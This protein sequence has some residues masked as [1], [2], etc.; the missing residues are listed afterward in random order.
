VVIAEVIKNVL[1]K[2]TLCLGRHQAA[3]YILLAPTNLHLTRIIINWL[4]MNIMICLSSLS[5]YNPFISKH[6][7]KTSGPKA[8]Q[9]A[10]L[11]T[12]PKKNFV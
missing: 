8:P 11:Q 6:G 12:N 7:I 3:V 5:N 2:T 9:F 1:S 10:I 4:M